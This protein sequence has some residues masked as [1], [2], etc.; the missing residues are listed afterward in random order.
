MV[1]VYAYESPSAAR[2]YSGEKI[3]ALRDE[4]EAS[5]RFAPC[6]V[7]GGVLGTVWKVRDCETNRYFNSMPATFMSR[8]S[9]QLCADNLNANA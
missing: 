7:F 5:A 6:A 2:L 9:A 3:R 1:K 4:Q 8:E